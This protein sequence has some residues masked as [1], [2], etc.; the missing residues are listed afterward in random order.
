M[1]HMI[2]APDVS[3]HDQD[4]ILHRVDNASCPAIERFPNRLHL[5][6]DFLIV[7]PDAFH[8]AQRMFPLTVQNNFFRQQQIN[9]HTNQFTLSRAS[10][11]S[12]GLESLLQFFG[13]VNPGSNH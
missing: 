8:I 5:P 4:M 2:P 3:R 10:R 1:P 6:H 11:Q 13:K 7:F 9:R 12:Q